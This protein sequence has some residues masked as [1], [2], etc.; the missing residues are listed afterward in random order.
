MP[1]RKKAKG[2]ARKAAKEAK[3]KEEGGRAVKGG[4]QRQGESVEAMMNRL[5]ICSHGC[6]SLS[7][8]EAK[9]SEDFI[10]AFLEAFF[11][12]VDMVDGF[13]AATDTTKE[14]YGE[15]Y[16]SKLDAIISIFLYNGTDN[17]LDG[18]NKAAQQ[19]ASLAAYFEEYNA[20]EVCKTKAR[21]NY[22][23]V[24]ELERA[25]GNT[26]VSYYRKRIPCSCLDEKYK[27]VKSLKKMGFCYN[28]SCSHPD[29]RVERSKMFC[30]T[31]CGEANYCSVECQRADWKKKHGQLCGKVAKIKAEFESNQT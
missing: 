7:A 27:K 10:D 22:S 25:D 8:G 20:Y 24:I 16:A 29:R 15:I 31:R 1:S 9:T 21:I 28:P 14:V 17:I 13:E 18:N 26:L 19:F 3:A 6:P 23:K 12:K 30:C 5:T 11:S 2:K 4:I